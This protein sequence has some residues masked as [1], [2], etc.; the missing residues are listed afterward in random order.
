MGSHIQALLITMIVT[1]LPAWLFSRLFTPATSMFGPAQAI[2][3][4]FPTTYLLHAC[5]AVMTKGL[6]GG[7]LA[8]DAL[9]LGAFALG[10][11]LVTGCRTRTSS[12]ACSRVKGVNRGG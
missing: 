12:Q 3:A 5:V 7:A 10:F 6:G 4:A 8:E 1:M 9:A 2:A 11:D